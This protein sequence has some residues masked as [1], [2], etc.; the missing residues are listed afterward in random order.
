MFLAMKGPAVLR[1]VHEDS[2]ELILALMISLEVVLNQFSANSAVASRMINHA[3][4]TYW[5]GIQ[6]HSRLLWMVL[7]M[8][9]KLRH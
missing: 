9:W 5:L 2:K 7:K 1:L 3:D 8:N 4:Q 6:Y